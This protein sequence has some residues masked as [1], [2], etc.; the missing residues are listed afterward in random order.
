MVAAPGR[1][2]IGVMGG[3]FDPVHAGHLIVAS[4]A[5]HALNLNEVLFVPAANPWQ[6]APLAPIEHRLEMVRRAIAHEP[7]FVLNDVDVRRGGNT[8]SVDTLT[9]LKKQFSDADFFLL[10]GSDAVASL[11]T[12]KDFERI[13]SLAH[14]VSLTR[15][16]HVATADDLPA[17]AVTLLP[18][19]AIDISSTDCRDRLRYG[20]PV[21]F[22]V[23]SPV[24]DYVMEH[25]LYRRDA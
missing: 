6:K 22:M 18:V 3:T 25:Q 2:R 11:P 5:L 10:L 9:D 17:G 21:R 23:T 12:W 16:G 14:V 1:R 24:Y 15:P 7:R 4:E 19:P 20:R 8:Y 13:F